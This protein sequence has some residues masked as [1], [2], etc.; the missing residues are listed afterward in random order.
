L[1]ERAATRISTILLD[2]C[3][4]VCARDVFWSFLTCL[5]CPIFPPQPQICSVLISISLTVWGRVLLLKI[6]WYLGVGVCTGFLL[7]LGNG[8]HEKDVRLSA[9]M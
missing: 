7:T 1:G 6:A 9:P 5:S 8:W 4:D 2:F 3:A